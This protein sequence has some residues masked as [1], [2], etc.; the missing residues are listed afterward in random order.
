MAEQV[1]DAKQLRGWSETDL[2]ARLGEL[3]RELWHSRIKIASGALQQP[4]RLRQMRHAI[5]RILTVLSEER[6]KAR[7]GHP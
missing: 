1:V 4:H 5:A 6:R 7:M 2:H 3:R